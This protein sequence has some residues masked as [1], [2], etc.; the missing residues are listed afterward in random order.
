MGAPR[1]VL[2]LRYHEI[3]LKGRNR[4]YFVRRLVANVERALAGLPVGAVR[5][6]SARLVLPLGDVAAWPAARTRLAR[7]FGL[8]NVALAHEVALATRGGDAA[9]EIARLGRLIVERLA[10]V[11]VESFRVQTKRSD[12]R[13]GLTSPEVNRLVG[14]TIQQATGARVD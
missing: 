4:P 2:V 10:G 7:V 8:A 14:A 1:H 6:A 13:F 11:E 5:R 3:A 9:T 12:K